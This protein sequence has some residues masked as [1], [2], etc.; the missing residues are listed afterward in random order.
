MATR[1][2]GA[3][4][5]TVAFSIAGG[6]INEI[7]PYLISAV[8]FWTFII[9]AL[10]NFIMLIPIYFFYLETANRHLED[11]DMLF[12]SESP[13]VWRAEKDFAEKQ[14]IGVGVS[15]GA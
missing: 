5:A 8:N 12:A 2:K 9:F 3:A 1:A 11:L 4:L 6:V 7:I 13:L 15:E 14:R 10:I